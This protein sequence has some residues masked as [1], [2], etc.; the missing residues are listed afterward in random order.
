MVPERVRNVPKMV[1]ANVEITRTRFHACS[2]PLRRCTMA[3][4]MNAVPISQGSSAAFSTGS[5]A[6]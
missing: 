5:H 6:Q 1:S 4:W 2:M 3:E